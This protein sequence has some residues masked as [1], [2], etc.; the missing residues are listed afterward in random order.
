M[1]LRITRIECVG[2]D[3]KGQTFADGCTKYRWVYTVDAPFVNR[4][5]ACQKARAISTTW[6]QRGIWNARYGE[7]S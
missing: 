5:N 3:G 1:N 2:I 6:Q 4:C 7:M